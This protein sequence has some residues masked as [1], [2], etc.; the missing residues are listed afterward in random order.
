MIPSVA[1]PPAV[2]YV[3][4]TTTLPAAYFTEPPPDHGTR[5]TVVGSD[6]IPTFWDMDDET[7]DQVRVWLSQSRLAVCRSMPYSPEVPLWDAS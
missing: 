6:D 5:L 4:M 3:V 2:A 1:K 7:A